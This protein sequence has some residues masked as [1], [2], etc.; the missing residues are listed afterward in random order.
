MISSIYINVVL[1]RVNYHCVCLLLHRPFV[2]MNTSF[3]AHALEVCNRN[4]HI[5][6]SM[7]EEI[8]KHFLVTL[9]WSLTT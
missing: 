4:G 5:I 6:I 7:A 3:S 2:R 9:P 1:L 8:E